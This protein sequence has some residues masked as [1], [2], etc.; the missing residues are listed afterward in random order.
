MHDNGEHAE[1]LSITGSFSGLVREQRLCDIALC[2]LAALFASC[3]WPSFSLGPF[4]LDD[5]AL[6][7]SFSHAPFSRIWAFDHFGQLRPIKNLYFW[8]LARDPELASTLRSCSMLAA[9]GC[10]WLVRSLSLTLGAPPLW[11]AGAAALWLLNPTTATGVVWLSASNYLLALLGILLYALAL[12]SAGE[13]HYATASRRGKLLWLLG[14]AALLFAALCHELALLTPLWL[15]LRARTSRL[16]HWLRDIVLPLGVGVLAVAVLPLLLRALHTAPPLA[17]R[18]SL[19]SLP[20]MAAAAYNLEQNVRMWLCL[21]GSFGVLLSQSSALQPAL[22][23]T[24]WLSALLCIRLLWKLGK[25]AKRVVD[26][27]FWVLLFLLPLVNLIPIG[28]T[29]VAMHY[30]IIPGVGLAWLAASAIVYL[31]RRLPRQATQLTLLLFAVLLLGWQ[32]AF[33]HCVQA[34]RSELG[35]YES[36]LHNYPANLDARVNLIAAYAQT[37]HVAEAEGLLEQSLPMAPGHPGLLRDQLSLL[38]QTERTDEALE[39]LDA[40][41]ELVDGDPELTLER[42][43]VLARVG[44]R[45]EEAEQLFRQVLSMREQAELRAIAGYQLANM[46]VEAT[47]LPDAQRLLRQLHEEFPHDED[48]TLALGLI[49]E[50]IQNKKAPEKPKLPKSRVPRAR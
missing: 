18:S 35:L 44:G 25:R 8:W 49:E 34:F 15:M 3:V 30:L 20:L 24:T 21:E 6:V 45:N 2:L 40:H 39:W 26:A 11:A 43:M 29:P 41:S 28:N 42:A 38:V 14:H 19:P 1:R 47:R 31:A 9:I 7:E 10:T 16:S 17:Y 27:L 4:G 36:T 48:L 23:A 37:G 50:M 46:W 22:A 12:Q 33:R 5:Q 32:P 13:W